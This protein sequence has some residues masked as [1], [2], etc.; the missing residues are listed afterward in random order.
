MHVEDII[1]LVPILQMLLNITQ[2]YLPFDAPAI[3]RTCR[4]TNVKFH[5]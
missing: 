1:H 2:F 5:V 3:R 4:W